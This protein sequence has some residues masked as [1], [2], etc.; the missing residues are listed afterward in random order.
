MAED[1]ELERLVGLARAI[2]S[3][4]NPDLVPDRY[5][6]I[7]GANKGHVW[8]NDKPIDWNRNRIS[9]A[10][11][12]YSYKG[13][14]D[15]LGDQLR[16]INTDGY[17]VQDQAS[18][19]IVLSRQG[20][21]SRSRIVDADFWHEGVFVI[22]LQDAGAPHID[23]HDIAM[24]IEE[25]KP[26]GQTWFTVRSFARYAVFE[27]VWGHLH[28]QTLSITDRM[29]EKLGHGG[30]DGGLDN[31]V[32]PSYRSQGRVRKMYFPVVWATHGVTLEG[33]IGYGGVGSGRD[34]DI[35]QGYGAG[36]SLRH[37]FIP[38]GWRRTGTTMEGSLGHAIAG[39]DAELSFDGQRFYRPKPPRKGAISDRLKE[40]IQR[41]FIPVIR[42]TISEYDN[43]RIGHS[44]LGRGAWLSFLGT[45]FY[46]P[47]GDPAPYLA[48]EVLGVALNVLRRTFYRV[49]DGLTIE[50]DHSRT[51]VLFPDGR[52]EIH[53][54]KILTE[55]LMFSDVAE[56]SGIAGDVQ[57]AQYDQTGSVLQ[58]ALTTDS[59]LPANIDIPANTGHT[60]NYLNEDEAASQADFQGTTYFALYSDFVM[61]AQIQRS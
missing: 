19:I 20:K 8:R 11:T 61:E 10:I 30:L 31:S 51:G 42:H 14:N 15:R 45:R 50:A 1:N 22:Y 23:P 7:A 9:T 28:G 25:L 55:M 5:L 48:H 2:P 12:R 53:V 36:A 44:Y 49:A 13:S 32:S 59:N 3:M 4:R 56:Q 37:S 60:N 52:Y 43:G 39:V 16:E 47:S 33:R 57:R 6:K 29:N 58:G 27:M 35:M 40:E 26:A 34:D 41:T 46:N 38:V 24:V 17:Y 21:L 18:Q 54:S